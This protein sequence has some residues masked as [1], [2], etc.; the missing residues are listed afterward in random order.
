MLWKGPVCFC[1]RIFTKSVG[2]IRL[3]ASAPVDSPA[4]IF[5]QN[6]A[7]RPPAPIRFLMGS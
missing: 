1:I 6:G 5:F 7:S 4:T 3:A 2:D